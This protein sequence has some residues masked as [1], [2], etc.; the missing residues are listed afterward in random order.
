M[1]H[2]SVVVVS[3]NVRDLLV[4]C[5]DALLSDLHSTAIESRVVVVDNAS[6]DGSAETIRARFPPVELIAC[7][8]NVGF[9]AGNNAGLRALGL[10]HSLPGF[11]T[12]PLLP[13]STGRGGG[14]EDFILLLNPDTEVQ[15]GSVSNMLDAMRARP[16]AAVVTS[17][18]SYGDGSF[19]H[20]A[21]HFPGLWQLY[22]DLFRM[23]PRLY[24]SRLNGRYPRRLYDA[25]QPFEI[26][27]PL[28]AVML[29]RAEAIRQ[30]GL[31]DESFALYCEEIDWCARFKEA[32]W[33]NYCAPA[34]HVIHH[35]ARSTSQVKAESFVKLWTARYRLHTK[36]PHFAP[37]WLARR[38]VLAGMR[39]KMRGASEERQAACRRII[40]VWNSK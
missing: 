21:F 33:R 2:L 15:P 20:S 13:P 18:L 12:P 25:G 29:V 36:H 34:A 19:Q 37:L 5:L 26:D 40:D 6:R 7:E 1:N 14:G 17:R 28:G 27:H 24:E 38:M 32:G 9:A 4:R 11:A 16:D 31:F 10:P 35:G 3:W 23:S 22:I 39:R 8:E 30:A